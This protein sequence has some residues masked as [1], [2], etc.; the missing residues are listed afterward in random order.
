MTLDWLRWLISTFTSVVAF[1]TTFTRAEPFCITPRTTHNLYLYYI[2]SAQLHKMSSL[3]RV[4]KFRNFSAQFVV[5]IAT[6]P[7]S[8]SQFRSRT[9]RVS[10]RSLPRA[11]ICTLNAKVCEAQLNDSLLTKRFRNDGSISV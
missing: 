3:F 9:S 4:P 7:K 10:S 2:R 1:S 8:Q 6:T 5:E 11:L